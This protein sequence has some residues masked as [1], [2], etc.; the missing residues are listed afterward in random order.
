MHE[1]LLE[2]GQDDV[3]VVFPF[4]RM[5]SVIS[6]T[7]S[8]IDVVSERNPKI[9]FPSELHGLDDVS[10]I[11]ESAIV[12]ADSDAN[13]QTRQSRSKVTLRVADYKRLDDGVFL[14]DTLIDFW[15]Q[16]YVSN[17]HACVN[18]RI[19][20]NQMPAH[21]INIANKDVVP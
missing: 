1:F 21:C 14:N 19:I 6:D 16:W 20:T 7:D 15:H 2:R 13:M 3:L 10:F 9:T 18:R 5:V 4:R 17:Q 11:F 12:C 8:S